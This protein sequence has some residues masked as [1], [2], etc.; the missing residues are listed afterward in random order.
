MVKSKNLKSAENQQERLLYL[1]F[2]DGEGCFSDLTTTIIPFFDKYPLKTIKNKDFNMFRKIRQKLVDEKQIN[3]SKETVI[4][5][6][7][8]AYTMNNNG[9]NKKRTFF[10]TKKLIES[11][12]TGR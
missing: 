2:I 3:Y 10:E 4:G 7:K 5:M 12:T 1:G 11:S 6:V 8:H 9:S